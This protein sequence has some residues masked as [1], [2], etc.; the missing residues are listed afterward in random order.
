M[1]E[2]TREAYFV[3]QDG[4]GCID[5][6]KE[7]KSV[8]RM[9]RASGAYDG[10]KYIIGSLSGDVDAISKTYPGILKIP[11][12]RTIFKYDASPEYISIIQ[13]SG[14]IRES[15]MDRLLQKF[16]LGKGGM[17]Y[18]KM[19][20]SEKVINFFWDDPV[21]QGFNRA[22]SGRKPVV[23]YKLSPNILKVSLSETG[24]YERPPYEPYRQALIVELDRSSTGS[25]LIS[26][27]LKREVERISDYPINVQSFSIIEK[28]LKETI[29]TRA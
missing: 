21:R 8:S 7:M 4:S 16:K 28:G 14:G 10:K 29:K 20:G 25:S 17:S 23:W 2:P 12:K 24:L 11:V 18:T 22:G 1:V 5:R 26:E 13:M 6:I 27:I 9:Y 19:R 15:K 3:V